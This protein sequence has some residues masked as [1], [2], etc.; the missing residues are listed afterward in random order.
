MERIRRSKKPSYTI[1]IVLTAIILT[2]GYATFA[3]PLAHK[4]STILFDNSR[5]GP[6]N[7]NTPNNNQNN[8]QSTNTNN[9]QVPTKQNNNYNNNSISTKQWDVSFIDAK[10]EN[11][12]GNV[13]E[14]YPVSYNKLSATFSVEFNNPED[15]ITYEFTVKNKGELDA[16][17]DGYDIIT[18]NNDNF[19]FD[20]EGLNKGDILK[21]NKT[22][23]IKI[24]TTYVSENQENTSSDNLSNET[25]KIV[26][27]LR[28]IQK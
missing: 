15:S 21:V 8:N 23:K 11:M 6:W 10:K 20:V 17:L 27:T 7:S 14:V 25:G 5:F 2:V 22:A 12:N 3:Q 16:K 4:L 24:K 28:Y 18:T 13:V 26:V 9:S 19:K 1:Y